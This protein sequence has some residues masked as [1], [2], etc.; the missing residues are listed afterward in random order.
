MKK[1]EMFFRC[2]ARKDGDVYV[3]VCIDLNLAFQGDTVEAA[4]K[5]LDTLIHEYLQDAIEHN[6]EHL[7]DLIDRPAPLNLRMR[8]YWIAFRQWAREV[9]GRA[10]ERKEALLFKESACVPT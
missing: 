6:R 9:R 7:A 8:Y 5:G 10:P 4:R 3:A 2:Y 1:P